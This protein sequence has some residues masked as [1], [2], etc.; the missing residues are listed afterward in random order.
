[1]VVGYFGPVIKATPA[2]WTHWLTLSLSKFNVYSNPIPQHKNMAE[3]DILPNMGRDPGLIEPPSVDHLFPDH[4]SLRTVML[5]IWDSSETSTIAPN[6]RHW[7]IAWKV[8]K[9]SN[10]DDVHRLLGV[11]R[12]RGP[13]GDLLEHLTNW[14]PLTR[15]AASAGCHENTNSIPIGTLSLPQRKWLEGVAEAEPVLKPNG[16][17]N[18]QDWVISVLVQSIRNGLFAKESVESVLK[19]AGRREPL[20][21]A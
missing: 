7:A 16:W 17:W 14:G 20:L 15:S 10:G 8:G 19:Q 3:P 18:C 13:D 4:D 11:V 9:S 1:M 5:I 6:D 12:E 21:V 2:F